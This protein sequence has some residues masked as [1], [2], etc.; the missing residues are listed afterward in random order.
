MTWVVKV[1]EDGRV[2]ADFLIYMDDLRPIG[3]NEEEC[4][5]ATMRAAS[6]C[7]HIGIQDAPRKRIE[8]SRSP[9]PWEGSMVYTYDDKAGVRVL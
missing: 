6:V 8:V 5:R 4:W 3:P 1:R 7:N 2:D 9:G